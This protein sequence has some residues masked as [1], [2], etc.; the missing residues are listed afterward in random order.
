M[1]P[2]GGEQMSQIRDG[3]VLYML[4]SVSIGSSDVQ[5]VSVWLCVMV[6]ALDVDCF[7]PFSIYILRS[8]YFIN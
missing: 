5:S 7:Q 3:Y 6:M 2:W 8:L 4:H 1:F